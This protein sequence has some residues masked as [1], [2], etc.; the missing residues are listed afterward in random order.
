MVKTRTII[1]FLRRLGITLIFLPELFTTPFGIALI[2]IS[3]HLS[4]RLE[5]RQNKRLQEMVKYYL[6]HTGPFSSDTAGK[7]IAS[8]SVKLY[9]RSEEHVIPQQFIGNHSF[10][11]NIT[12]SVWQSWHDMRSRTV[13]YTMDKQ[14]HS[15]GYKAGDNFKVECGLPNTQSK[16]KKVIHHMINMESLSQHYE[17]EDSDAVHS[18][19]ARTS[20]A[21]DRV[22]H[23]SVNKRLLSQC[24]NTTSIGQTKV[25][26]T[27]NIALLLHRYEEAM[28]KIALNA[29]RDNYSYHDLIS[30]GNVIGGY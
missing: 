13:H 5:A 22:M 18:N 16:T 7:Y 24:Y 11:I 25:N 17:G 29:L 10:E 27:T 15:L 12:P 26:H 30:R 3:R 23:H 28:C 2:L 14:R 19:R 1:R 20:D 8:S 6:A 21:V 4:K 9:T